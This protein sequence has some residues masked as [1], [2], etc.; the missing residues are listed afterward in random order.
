LAGKD[1]QLAYGKESF[2]VTLEEEIETEVIEPK[3]DLALENFQAEFK[4]ALGNPVASAPLT[5]LVHEGEEVV[6]V[7]SDFTRLAYRTS[8]YLN[9]LLDELNQAGIKDENITVVIA[10]GTHRSQNEEEDI[11]VVGEEVYQRVDIEQHDCQAEDLKNLGNTSRG[12]EV[13]INR[14]V[15]EA[16][17]LILTGGIN[18]H[19]IA[20]FGGGRKS[21]LPGVAGYNSI[22]ENHSLALEATAD[23]N[24]AVEAT[25]IRP[26]VLKG[27]IVAED[28][29]EAAQKLEPDFIINVVVNG[30]KEYLTFAAG[31]L[32][33][34]FIAGTK[35]A[36]EAFGI[37]VA[38]KFDLILTSCGGYPKDIQLYQSIK[39]LINAG[40]A[41]K[42]GGTIVLFSNCSQGVGNDKFL[43]WFDYGSPEKIREALH[44]EFS[45]L[46]YVALMAAEISTRNN[47]ILVSE[48][49]DEVVARVGMIPA[50]SAQKALIKAKKLGEIKKAAIMPQGALTFPI[51]K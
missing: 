8:G 44:N 37:P 22:Q 2:T 21:I 49:A 1:Y 12:T 41:I 29:L 14:T 7:A 3:S 17:R 23:S 43:D 5:E 24:F 36:E 18:Y 30:N 26:G 46:G 40:Y 28:M 38:D 45:M 9:L 19:M 50:A 48:L 16:D 42:E 51:V 33:E 13:K 4:K 34:A 35:V 31:D 15:Y 10:S 6:I 20:G 39:P 47:V 32:K 11:A 27:N 25:K